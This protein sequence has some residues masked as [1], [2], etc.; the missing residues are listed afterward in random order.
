MRIYADIFN[1]YFLTDVSAVA[2][3]RKRQSKN[4]LVV[5]NDATTYRVPHMRQM[6]VLQ[7]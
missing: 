3:L 5:T 1:R 6:C 7:E 4:I 2:D